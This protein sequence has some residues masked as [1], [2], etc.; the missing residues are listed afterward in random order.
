VF[1]P[2]WLVDREPDHPVVGGHLPA[3]ALD[4]VSAIADFIAAVTGLD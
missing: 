1:V 4:D 2:N 3:F